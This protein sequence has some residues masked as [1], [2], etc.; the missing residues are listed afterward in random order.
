MIR[1]HEPLAELIGGP[2]DGLTIAVS[3]T[4]FGRM[5]DELRG[6]VDTPNGGYRLDALI[7]HHDGSLC[8]GRYA[9][10]EDPSGTAC[11]CVAPALRSDC[12][13]HRDTWR[14]V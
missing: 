4:L 3:S 9:Y 2:L 12:P 5:P 10:R 6:S 13:V 11:T 14:W 7:H 1:H 8:G